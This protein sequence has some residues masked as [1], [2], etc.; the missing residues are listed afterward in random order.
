MVLN[1]TRE[2]LYNARWHCTEVKNGK[3]PVVVLVPN[4]F[5][6]SMRLR[7][8]VE[9]TCC[10]GSCDCCNGA[11]PDYA[12]LPVDVFWTARRLPISARLPIRRRCG[13]ARIL[14]NVDCLGRKHDFT[15]LRMS[16]I[17]DLPRHAAHGRT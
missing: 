17:P 7:L 4:P 15:S 5:I 11:L 14:G 6:R 8:C 9:C 2:G 13:V 1:G 3:Q 10:D 12:T 16:V